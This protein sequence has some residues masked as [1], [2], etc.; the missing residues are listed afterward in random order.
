MKT[1]NKSF[2]TGNAKETSQE[3]KY[4]EKGT[5]TQDRTG[6]KDSATSYR[7]SVIERLFCDKS[8]Y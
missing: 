8:K 3:E 6:S 7:V 4:Q 5:S 2:G 1:E